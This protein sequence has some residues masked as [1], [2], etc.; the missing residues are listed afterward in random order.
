MIKASLNS[1]L[2][3]MPRCPL[4]RSFWLKMR[5]L[6]IDGCN[7]LLFHFHRIRHF[8]LLQLCA[9]FLGEH[10]IELR[11]DYFNVRKGAH[12]LL[13]VFD[14][15]YS[16]LLNRWTQSRSQRHM[17]LGLYR[18]RLIT[19]ILWISKPYQP[20]RAGSQ[21][22]FS[23]NIILKVWIHYA[24]ILSLLVRLCLQGVLM[25]AILTLIPN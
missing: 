24:S 20:T 4:I 18:L 3:V 13:R 17:T 10:L 22:G 25:I 23:Q 1:C 5:I 11:A 21:Q 9:L 16:I 15:K 14:D 6:S 2:L 19:P 8:A 7:G 12:L